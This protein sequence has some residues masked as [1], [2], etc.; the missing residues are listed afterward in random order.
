MM[1][2]ET[3]G[4]GLALAV[5]LQRDEA[6]MQQFSISSV[7]S[8]DLPLVTG[9]VSR[10]TCPI[11]RNVWSGNYRQITQALELPLTAGEGWSLVHYLTSTPSSQE[12]E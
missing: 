10:V 7:T 4:T 8:L 5:W 1:G 12:N 3:A 2:H 9:H 6:I 11:S